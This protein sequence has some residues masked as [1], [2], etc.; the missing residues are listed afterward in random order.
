MFTPFFCLTLCFSYLVKEL[1]FYSCSSDPKKKE[2]RLCQNIRQRGT[3]TVRL[4]SCEDVL[5]NCVYSHRLPLF[6]RR[7]REEKKRKISEVN[8]F[9]IYVN[10]FH[11]HAS[12]GIY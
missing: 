5:V 3:C 7:R 8:D 4:K 10:V 12:Y 2:A 9:F 6:I 11:S 1:M